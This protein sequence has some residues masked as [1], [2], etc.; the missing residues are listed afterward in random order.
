M[1]KFGLAAP[2]LLAAC[3]ATP[4]ARV[5]GGTCHGEA[6]DT[7]VGREATPT[8]LA[9]LQRASGAK[10]MRVVQPGMMIT[11]EFSPERVTVQLAPG[12]KIER[13]NCG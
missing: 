13:A 4:A 8:T 5:T 2:L 11:M 6:L 3:A 10:S 1:R 9:E 12:N 7:F